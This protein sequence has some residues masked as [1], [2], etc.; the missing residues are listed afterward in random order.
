MNGGLGQVMLT[1][2]VNTNMNSTM[3]G[4]LNGTDATFRGCSDTQVADLPY[5][6]AP[7]FSVAILLENIL[8]V[9]VV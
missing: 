4:I 2:T 7:T 3:V 5:E 8:A 9:K 1:L 6:P